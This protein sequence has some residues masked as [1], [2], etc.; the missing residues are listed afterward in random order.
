MLLFQGVLL[1]ILD[2]CVLSSQVTIRMSRVPSNVLAKGRGL[3]KGG[4]GHGEWG[5]TMR[6]ECMSSAPVCERVT[7]LVCI[8]S[9]FIEVA[10]WCESN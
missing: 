10:V 8:S 2:Y 9:F 6:R 1:D 4:P 5:V 7:A 3:G